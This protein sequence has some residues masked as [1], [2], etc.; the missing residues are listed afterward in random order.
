MPI[1][2]IATHLQ[3][4]GWVEFGSKANADEFAKS[5]IA[6]G[7]ERYSNT[8]FAVKGYNPYAAP[9][10]NAKQ[11]QAPAKPTPEPVQ[12]AQPQPSQ[13][14]SMLGE[15]APHC[16]KRNRLIIKVHRLTGKRSDD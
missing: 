7:M 15:A 12:S 16:L 1:Q 4:N 8:G 10:A 6:K 9:K 11:S 3:N 5:D 2:D 14:V 13:S